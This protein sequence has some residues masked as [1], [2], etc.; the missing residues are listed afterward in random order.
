MMWRPRTDLRRQPP[1]SKAVALLVELQGSM[2]PTTGFA[3]VSHRYQRCASLSTLWRNCVLEMVGHV[4]FA[5][6]L[7]DP[8]G[9][10]G[11][12]NPCPGGRSGKLEYWK[13]G[14]PGDFCS[15]FHHSNHPLIQ[16][17][18]MDARPGL[19][20][21]NSDLQTDGSTTSPCAR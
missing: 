3:P 1:A 8:N 2:D 11:Y 18:E 4:R 15:T 9:V 13:N 5:R 12:H 17:L 10:C 16:T 14:M 20:P 21:G 19:A 7:S 6:L